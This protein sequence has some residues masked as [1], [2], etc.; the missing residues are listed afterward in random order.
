MIK[1]VS[2]DGGTLQEPVVTAF[3]DTKDEVPATGAATEVKGLEGTL[4]SGSIIYTA[5]LEVALLKSDDTWEWG[6]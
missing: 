3:A 4:S 1:L 2:I 6:E 5:K